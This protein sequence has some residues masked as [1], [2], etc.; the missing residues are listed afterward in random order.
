MCHDVHKITTVVKLYFFHTFQIECACVCVLLQVLYL[1]QSMYGYPQGNGAAGLVQW[2]LHFLLWHP[3]A[4]HCSGWKLWEN[5]SFCL[6][7]CL[8]G[9]YV[10]LAHADELTIFVRDEE[11]IKAV[12]ESV[13][14]YS[15]AS[16]ARINWSNSK[17]G[18][19]TLVLKRQFQ[20]TS[21]NNFA[22]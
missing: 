13:S 11:D 1:L 3:A 5:T 7:Y 21:G 10:C 20:K 8:I 19:C 18:W 9:Q 16:L 22:V 14:V 15:G 2:L 12:E 6:Y 17:A 4:V